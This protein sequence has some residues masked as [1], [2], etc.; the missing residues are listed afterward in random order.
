M[1]WGN[2]DAGVKE[3]EM[4]FL[5]E[6]NQQKDECCGTSGRKF[7]KVCVYCPNYER[8]IKRKKKEKSEEKKDE[9]DH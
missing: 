2:D 1:E 3:Y 7:R 8:W 6:K 9:K 4:C 5:Y